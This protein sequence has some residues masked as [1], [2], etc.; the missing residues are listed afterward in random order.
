MKL[1]IYQILHVASMVVL[2]AFTFM[3][4][5]NPDPKGKKKTMMITGIMSLLMLIGGFGMLAVLKYGFPAWVLLKIV[6]WLGVSGMA[7]MAYRK[8]E[9]MGTWKF[10][11]LAF[12]LV[13]ILTVY[14]KSSFE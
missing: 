1:Q 5:A 12:L 14:L 2:T 10:M 6:C 7:G 8:P 11:S 13:A 4:F 3:A 9:K